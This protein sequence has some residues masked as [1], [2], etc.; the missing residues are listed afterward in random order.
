MC[1][2]S[3]CFTAKSFVDFRT[4]QELSIKATTGPTER[5]APPKRTNTMVVITRLEASV[6]PSQRFRGE[7]VVE[8]EVEVGGEE[9][10]DG[11]R[12]GVMGGHGVRGLMVVMMMVVGV[13]TID[14]DNGDKGYI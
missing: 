7:G 12:V 13:L 4:T 3:G 14:N 8:G 9:H 11:H 10:G 2:I 6:H 5:R 1:I